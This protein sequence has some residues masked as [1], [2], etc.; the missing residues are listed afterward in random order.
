[1]K[2]FE[3]IIKSNN[4]YR[5]YKY[6]TL[7]NEL[8]GLIIHDPNIIISNLTLSVNLGYFS[9][10]ELKSSRTDNKLSDVELKSS[11]TDNKLSDVELKSSRTDNKL[12]DVDNKLSDEVEGIAHLL[13]HLLFLGS[14]KYNKDF[15][16]IVAEYG[17]NCNAF[18]IGENTNYFFTIP[19]EYI[20]NVIDPFINMFIDPLLK[21]EFIDEEI[22]VVD[23]EYH[24]NKSNNS[25]R[26][27]TILKQNMSKLNPISKFTCGNIESFS[28][29]DIE[30]DVRNFFNNYSAHIMKLIIISGKPIDD[31][32]KIAKLFEKIPNKEISKYQNKNL[33]TNTYLDF[34]SEKLFFDKKQKNY[35][36][37]LIVGSLTKV[38]PYDYNNKL[39]IYW[40]LPRKLYNSQCRVDMIINYILN[41]KGINS[42]SYILKKL[43]LVYSLSFGLLEEIGDYSIICMEI[44]LTLKGFDNI[45]VI[46]KIIYEYIYQLD[47]KDLTKIIDELNFILKEDFSAFEITNKINYI[48]DLSIL[49]QKNINPKYILNY[50][51]C[52]LEYTEKFKQ[53]FTKFCNNVTENNSVIILSSKK[54]KKN[55]LNKSKHYGIEYENGT[56]ND[57][58]NTDEK[59][60]YDSLQ[61]PKN[62][63]FLKI[64]KTL[65][66]NSSLEAENYNNPILINKNKNKIY[67]KFDNKFQ[68]KKTIVNTFIRLPYMSKNIYN[69]VL[70]II[71]IECINHILE[72][73]RYYFDTANCYN[74]ISIDKNSIYI[75]YEGFN[76]GLKKFILLYITTLKNFNDKNVFN[77]IKEKLKLI[78]KNKEF[79]DPLIVINEFVRYNM[80]YNSFSESQL[81]MALDNIE[82]KDIRKNLFNN[83]C[84]ITLIQGYIDKQ[85]ALEL[86]ELFNFNDKSQDKYINKL[87]KDI[88]LN[89]QIIKETKQDYCFIRKNKLNDIKIKKMIHLDVDNVISVCCNI[90]YIAK[91]YK[92][93]VILEL[94][95]N[96]INKNFYKELRVNKQLGYYVS[97]LIIPIGDF[98]EPFYQYRFIIE[99][100]KNIIYIAEQ[101]KKFINEHIKYIEDIDENKLNIIK[102]S[103]INKLNNPPQ[104]LMKDAY[105]NFEKILI[106][107]DN[108]YKAKLIKI[109][110]KINI[111]DIIIFY[112]KF[113]SDGQKSIYCYK[114]TI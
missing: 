107:Q 35:P 51:Y 38:I 37:P 8:S 67:W 29:P 68:T 85:T 17:G 13:E 12:S 99:T 20:D 23:A 11:R 26:I 6:F 5:T 88:V 100:R 41:N 57:L 82:Y 109:I 79:N 114:G 59:I 48:N 14:K 102:K 70:S 84:S 61:L 7:N 91:D 71:Y 65:I 10:S 30:G 63:I 72:P 15:N 24:K 75:T 32:I 2:I 36:K 22:L 25:E 73:Y 1:M 16:Q 76:E 89:N 97:T 80:E 9:D 101:I 93:Y 43:F 42:L 33:S 47:K 60:I 21:K 98:T 96:F 34:T 54:Y 66:T 53:L 52:S 104:Y 86:G 46:N 78:I 28:K 69:N 55:N 108:D 87:N 103:F 19:D 92:K 3:N 95:D 50:E 111:D 49:L 113:I 105:N 77:I 106:F 83:A 27:I 110:E 74:D 4:D 112:K 94:C 81:L 56:F 62:N 39:Y 31:I 40:Q 45:K 44:N 90:G 58:S 18:T 64:E